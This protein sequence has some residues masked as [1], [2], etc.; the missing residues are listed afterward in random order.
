M[1]DE[2]MDFG[3][4]LEAYEDEQ[5]VRPHGDLVRTEPEPAPSGPDRLHLDTDEDMDFGA[6]LEAFESGHPS[7]ERGT[8]RSPKQG[9][10]VAGPIVSLDLES[11]LVDIGAKAEAVIR[12]EDLTD[13]DG[14]LRFETGDIVTVKVMGRDEDSG[15]L[16][17]RP[18]DAPAFGGADLEVG[19]L[20]E[21]TVTSTNKGGVE[22]TLGRTRAFCPI[23]QLSD[24]YVE[25]SSSYVGRKLR[26]LVTQAEPS[27]RNLVLSRRAHLEEKKK[28][29]AEAARARLEIGTTMPGR[30][31]ALESFGAFVDLGGVEG[32]VHVSE[33]SHQRVGHP[34][35]L[36]EIG[37]QVDVKILDIDRDPKG[38]DRISL[39]RKALER[40]PW[41][42]AVQNWP[43]GKTAEG[44]VKRLESFGA[45]V[46]L[47]PGVEG[48]VHISELG[49]GRRIHHPRE[50]LEPGQTLGVR[51]LKLEA[52]R[53]RISLQPLDASEFRGDGDPSVQ[54]DVADALRRHQ[55]DGSFGSMAH[56]FKSA[57]K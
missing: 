43:E 2:T 52:E 49:R 25:D 13:D 44:K 54:E 18:I 7:P 51:V 9:D 8:G 24:R 5:G 14:A 34:K 27:R 37:Q 38:R 41:L 35:E 19:Q 1:T 30:V 3:K 53:Q 32:L 33:L 40:D 11:A 6:A 16:R 26:F 47:Q 20:V 42:D 22:V 46:E 29:E 12:T 28:A 48:L 39:S 50:V 57:K 23:S 21:G 10:T 56:F 4:I 45:F 15:A 17:V 36:L 31:T 55:K